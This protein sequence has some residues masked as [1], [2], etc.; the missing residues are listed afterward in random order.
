MKKFLLCFLAAIITTCLLSACSK[1][2]DNSND[3]L[4][5]VVTTFPQYDWVREILG[6]RLNEIELTLLL[7]DGIDLHNYQPSVEDITKISTCDLFIY[8]G[9]GSD[10]WVQNAL[11]NAKNEN[12]IVINMMESLG[13]KAKEEIIEGMEQ[14]HHHEE[15]H[16][17]EHEEEHH[18]MDEHI[19]LSLENARLICSYISNALEK[20]DEQHASI[21]SANVNTYNEK[22]AELDLKYQA[23]VNEAEMKTLLFGDHFPF[24]YLVDDYNLSYFAAFSGCF[25]ETEAS[26][27]TIIFLAN[28]I[29]ELD[30]T[31]VM[32]IETSDQ[33]IAKTI[34]ENTNNKNQKILVLDSMQSI[35]TKNIA[36]GITYLSIMESNLIVLK[37]ALF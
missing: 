11:N 30:L 37:E 25:A 1:H 35:T 15:D 36:S 23:V 33:L 28:K 8:V 34:V 2:S 4:S 3:K 20:I 18:H 5:I 32:V 29:D 21:Y 31:A 10:N 13:D 27:E 14:E 12:M 19:W 16:E 6:D 9:G 7:D 24:R 22:L 26:F 17:H